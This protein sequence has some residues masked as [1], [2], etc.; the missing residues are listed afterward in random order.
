MMA[1]ASSR[2][3]ASSAVSSRLVNMAACRPR[4]TALARDGFFE[5]IEGREQR[6][7]TIDLVAHEDV[8]VGNVFH[9]GRLHDRPLARPAHNDAAT[10]P[11]RRTNRQFD[12]RGFLLVDD[13]THIG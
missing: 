10:L 2:S 1:P 13:A 3:I 4:S 6:D 9:Q 8:A 12:A 11:D 5:V 7:G